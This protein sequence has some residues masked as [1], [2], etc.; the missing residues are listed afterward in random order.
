MAVPRRQPSPPRPSLYVLQSSLQSMWNQALHQ[1]RNAE[2]ELA[3]LQH[4]TALHSEKLKQFKAWNSTVRLDSVICARTHNTTQHTTQH[5]TTQHNTTQHTTYNTQHHRQT[6]YT[7]SDNTHRQTYTYINIH[8]RIITQSHTCLT[9]IHAQITRVLCERTKD[10]HRHTQ[11]PALNC[12]D[13]P[14]DKLKTTNNRHHPNLPSIDPHRHKR[15]VA[16]T[17]RTTDCSDRHKP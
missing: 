17:K 13:A 14:S 2:R 3:Q 7:Q 11:Q 1:H 5:N 4:E 15:T 8:S 10:T 12:N 16:F 6:H 9:Y